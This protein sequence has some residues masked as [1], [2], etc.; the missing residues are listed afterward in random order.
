MGTALVEINEFL[1]A[2]GRALQ[3]IIADGAN[4]PAEDITSSFAAKPISSIATL[5][6]TSADHRDL[7][8]RRPIPWAGKQY[9]LQPRY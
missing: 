1:H 7:A 8:H 4:I 5:E 3:S 6:I 9:V 2:N